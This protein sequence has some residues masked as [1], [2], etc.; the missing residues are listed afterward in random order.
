MGTFVLYLVISVLVFASQS[1]NAKSDGI[2]NGL[3]KNKKTKH[4][5]KVSGTIPEA[6]S[7][8]NDIDKIIK[9]NFSKKIEPSTLSNTTF[10]VEISGKKISGAFTYDHKEKVAYFSPSEIYPIN[11]EVAVNLTNGIKD[12]H[13]NSL[14]KF[15]YVFYTREGLWGDE[16]LLDSNAKQPSYPIVASLST[17]KTFAL[18]QR[19]VDWTAVNYVK[20]YTP[21]EGW[22]ESIPLNLGTGDAIDPQI[23]AG[24]NDD[25]WIISRHGSSSS[26]IFV[27][28][29]DSNRSLWEPGVALDD[30]FNFNDSNPQIAITKNG[31]AVAVWE[32]ADWPG[33]NIYGS[34]FDANTK[35][36]Q[37]EVLLEAGYFGAR[38]PQ[39]AISPEGNTVAVW[40][41]TEKVNNSYIYN[42]FASSYDISTG[43]WGIEQPLDWTE[44]NANYPDVALDSK[45][46]AIAVWRQHDG[47]GYFGSA[48]ADYH[49]YAKRFDVK[50]DVWSEPKLLQGGE[51]NVNFPKVNFDQNDS[52]IAVWMDYNTPSSIYAIH[53]NSESI[54]WGDPIQLDSND[55]DSRNPQF[56]IDKQGNALAFWHQ[57][58][59]SE[60]FVYYSRYDALTH[61]WEPATA[62]STIPGANPQLSIDKSGRGTV[63]W[64]YMNESANYNIY[65]KRFE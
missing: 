6:N 36:W 63:V 61:Q 28:R 8:N 23:V 53:F 3:H 16:I 18:W 51:V 15:N 40:H 39:V 30:G 20:S 33:P 17:G 54:E 50:S 49:L 2:K 7:K 56:A 44:H 38:N 27:N 21:G 19:R 25:T 14:S 55:N 57:K 31:D 5:L 35:Q 34:R 24:P 62:L 43:E 47:L 29:Y 10:F 58:V 11:A 4:A 13:G 48:S 41:Q 42:I 52:A 46:N 59:G 1:A 22:G 64:S 9:I 65:S 45:G 12:K 32:K 37:D 60:W 26:S